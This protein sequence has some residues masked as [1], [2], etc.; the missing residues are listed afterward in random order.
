MAL[1][2][3]GQQSVKF[4][5]R[6]DLFQIVDF[7]VKVTPIDSGGTLT[8]TALT[9][10]GDTDERITGPYSF[11]FRHID[12]PAVTVQLQFSQGRATYS[13]VNR[14]SWTITYHVTET[15]PDG[16]VRIIGSKEKRFDFDGKGRNRGIWW[17]LLAVSL[18]VLFVGMRV[19]QRK[20]RQ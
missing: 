20:L 12:E 5:F 7:D 10:Q 4:D 1:A 15:Q 14:G 8:I 17:L 19:I 16:S 18:A 9:A 2:S 13:V 3:H 11:S 6:S